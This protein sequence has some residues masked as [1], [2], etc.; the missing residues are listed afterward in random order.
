MWDG[1]AREGASGACPQQSVL[2]FAALALVQL[3]GEDDVLVVATELAHEALS[4]AQLQNIYRE[5]RWYISS[6]A[7][8]ATACRV[9]AND[10]FKVGLFVCLF[11]SYHTAG[12]MH[13]TKFKQLFHARG[14]VAVA[15]TVEVTEGEEV[16]VLR[17]VTGQGVEL[18]QHSTENTHTHTQHFRG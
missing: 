9:F 1:G 4:L 2:T 15:H 14:Q 6:S 16:K 7:Y 5:T 18:V 8:C 11:L 13:G 17:Q 3:E 12:Y 10:C